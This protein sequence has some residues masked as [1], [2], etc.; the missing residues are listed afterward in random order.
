EA[1]LR[2]LITLKALTYEPTGGVVAAVTTSLPEHWGGTRNWDYRFCWLRD[3]T[4][5]LDALMIA[6]YEDEARSFRDWL[7]RAVAGDPSQFQIMYGLAGER[8]LTELELEWL[9]GYL[10]ARPVRIGNAAYRQNQ[11]DVFGEIMDALYGG[12]HVGLTPSPDVWSLQRSLVDKLAQIWRDPDDGIWE[13]RGEPQHFT[14]SKVMAWVAVDRAL[15]SVER[16]G[17]TGPVERW[18]ELRDAIREDVL[19]RGYNAEVG[20]FTQ[21]YGSRALDASLLAMPLVG[22]LPAS[23]PRMRGTIEAIRRDLT[24]DG[25]VLRYAA[26]AADDGLPPGE[27]TF[28]LCSFWLANN[29]AMLGQ[30]REACALFEHLLSLRNDVGLLSEQY[31]PRA[32][33]LLGNFPQAFSHVALINTAYYLT[34]PELEVVPAGFANAT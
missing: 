34:N 6:G 9:P 14:H 25:L 30:H 32:G 19:T 28:L 2:S 4:F 13:V 5:T 10:G 18:R 15:K 7:L 12:Y 26:D 1:V 20:A 3:A 21:Y 16:Y 31:D 17:V 8:R 11:L 27:G 33:R 24:L 29:L 23:D 22:F